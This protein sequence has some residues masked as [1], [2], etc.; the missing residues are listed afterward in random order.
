V[1]PLRGNQWTTGGA[2]AFGSLVVG[3][4]AVLAG[5]AAATLLMR[6]AALH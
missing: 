3:I 6:L 4:L 1:T 5:V 2:Y